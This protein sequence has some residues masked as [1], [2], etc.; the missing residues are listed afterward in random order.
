L[1][2]AVVACRYDPAPEAADL[3]FRGGTVRT[4]EASTPV[5]SAVAVRRGRIVYVG[6]DARASAFVGPS[7]EVVELGGRLLL[8]GLHDTHVHP[9]SGGIEQGD[10]DLNA[11]ASV[12][13]IAGLLGDCAGRVAEGAWVRGG[14][15]QMT[16]FPG[17]EPP[18]EMLDS[19]VPDRPV[20]L[21]DATGHS[22][23]VNSRALALAGIDSRTPDP[24]PDGIVVRL[25]DGSPQGTLRESAMGLVTRH[26]PRHT[27]AE[28]RAGLARALQS[29][30]SFGITTLHEASADE[31]ALSAYAHAEAEGSLTARVLVALEVDHARGPGQVAE[32]ARLRGRYQGVLVRPVAAKVFLDGVIEGGTAALLAPYLDRSG[33][34][35][36][37]RWET[38]PLADLVAALD[39]AGFKAHFH[40]IGDRAVRTA[41]D[42]LER[43]RDRDG[44]AGPRHVLAH[45][46]LIDGADVARLAE[47]GVVASFQPLWAQ[48]DSYLT[49]LTEPRLGA[50]RSSRLYPLESVRATGAI[51]AAGSDWPVTSMDPLDAIEVAVTRRSPDEGAG[52]AWIPEERLSLEDAVLAYT[53]GGAFA[54]DLEME[55]GSIALGKRADLVVLERDLFTIAPVDIS[56]VRVDM[57]VL[58]GRVVYRRPG[59]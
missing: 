36:E 18:K 4:M 25:P 29:A 3:L 15:Y 49:D 51:L 57:T 42:A 43:Q 8:P 24:E 44:G 2:L 59:S 38:E 6:D 11:A 23:W 53:L 54:G 35:G 14:G 12:D 47:L 21:T 32:L 46:Q 56:E 19:L 22:A 52:E 20:Y 41:L 5:A 48:R 45:L 10:C 1:V 7:T 58:E 28:M 9:L 31:G 34:R 17:G 40:A 30:A 27:D 37:L 39:S 13:E 50:E 55:T 16:L 33:W 26:V